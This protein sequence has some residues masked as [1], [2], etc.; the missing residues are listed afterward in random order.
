MSMCTETISI[1][2]EGKDATSVPRVHRVLQSLAN[3]E[4]AASNTN[5]GDTSLSREREVALYFPG[6]VK[7]ALFPREC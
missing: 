3:T 4:A 6:N 5:S 7:V 1:S 2:R